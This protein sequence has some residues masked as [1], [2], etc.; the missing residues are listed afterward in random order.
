MISLVDTDIMV[1][2]SRGN[3]RVAVCLDSLTLPMISIVTAQ[4]LI[5]G[6]KDNRDLAA[7]DSL[8]SEFELAHID[9]AIGQLAY[10]LLKRYAKSSGLRPFDAWIAATA[11][12]NGYE[13]V[14]WNRKHFAM[15]E[16][17]RLYSPIY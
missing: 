10:N 13:V 9:S 3:S 1:D 7:I 16:G 6:A 4:E 14:S 8:I 2:V 15:I 17:L 12:N 5:V 11:M